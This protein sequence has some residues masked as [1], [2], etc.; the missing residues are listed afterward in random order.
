MK[1]GLRMPSLKKRI[2]A[3]TSWKRVAR[4]NLGLKAPRGWGWVTNPR[5]AA[6]N[7]V[8][9]RTTVG[10]DSVLSSRSSRT[11]ASGS[12]GCL[13][14]LMLGPLALLVWAGWP[15][16]IGLALLTVGVATARFAIIRNKRRLEQE[17]QALERD[18][19]LAA[20]ARRREQGRLAEAARLAR[21]SQRF[22]PEAAARL[23]SGEYW[24]GA[25]AEMLVE[26]LGQPAEIRERILKTKTKHTYCYSPIGKKRFALRIQLDN[27][28][29]VGW[30]GK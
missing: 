15:V 23:V 25:N 27:G 22:G 29:I 13:G 17:A 11:A 4:H 3:R 30:Q 2:S 5:K 6:Y 7:R 24:L 19:A 28:V 16:A 1:F 14:V 18:L 26:A 9:N 8:Y 10:L 12:A 21:L 20:E